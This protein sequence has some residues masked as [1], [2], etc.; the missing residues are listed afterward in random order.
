[1][2]AIITSTSI[3][4]NS[5]I[6]SKNY[7]TNQNIRIIQTKETIES[8][9]KIA[10]IKEIY[11]FD[12][13]GYKYKDYLSK[14]YNDVKLFV[15]D[16]YKFNNKG[17]SEIHLILNNLIHI[18]EDI[19]IL[20]ISGRYKINNITEFNNNL[21][22]FSEYEIIA[23]NNSD[24]IS[25]RLYIVRSKQIYEKLLIN[26]LNRCYERLFSV[27]GLRSLKNF[28]CRKLKPKNSKNTP[29][30]SIEWAFFEISKQ[31]LF[32]IKYVRKLHI[33]GQLA[34]NP[35]KIIEE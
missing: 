2:I 8:L 29:F 26:I 30:L 24:G 6:W 15:Q 14:Q 9:K 17:L 23:L 10:A 18:P 19:P 11:I 32:D 7:L 31:K 22:K 3:I 35:S 25:T 21:S 5:E 34:T 20:K 1:M 28:I 27:T 16:Q 33:K 13:S 4:E 12:N